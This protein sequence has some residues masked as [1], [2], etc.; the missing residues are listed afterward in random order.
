MKAKLLEGQSEIGANHLHGERK[1]IRRC[2]GRKYFAI[3][4]LRDIRNKS[5]ARSR[6]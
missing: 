1:T 2:S 6:K 5:A 3:C 4:Y